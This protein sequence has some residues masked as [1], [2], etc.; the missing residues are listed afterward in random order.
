MDYASKINECRR[1]LGEGV[2]PEA[3][4]FAA[5]LTSFLKSK[6]F[7]V[8][9]DMGGAVTVKLAAADKDK[10]E[11]A[12]KSKWSDSGTL[13]PV[14]RM[15]GHFAKPTQLAGGQIQITFKPGELNDLAAKL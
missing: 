7:K 8:K 9:G 14:V 4:K 6:G 15:V 12:L 2:T 11:K 5:D 1:M 13:S 10:L 3:K